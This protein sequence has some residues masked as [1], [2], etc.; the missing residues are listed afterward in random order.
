MF[1]ILLVTSLS[2]SDALNIISRIK[3]NP[4]LYSSYK[5]EMIQTIKEETKD[6]NWDAKAD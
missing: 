2:C 5:E 1:E 6:C 3:L 4:N